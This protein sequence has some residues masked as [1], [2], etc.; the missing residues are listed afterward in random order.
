MKEIA[1]REEQPLTVTEIRK[2]VNLIQEV[3][4]DI[5]KKDEHYGIIPGCKKPSLL[6]PGAE[7]IASTF[8]IHIESGE[9]LVEDLST[10]DKAHFRVTCKAYQNGVCLG[11]SVGVCSS[12]EEKYKW[13]KPTCD[14]EWEEADP[15]QR[16]EKWVKYGNEKA[17]KWKQIRTQ[18]ADLENTILQMADKR[19]YVAL[20]R[21]VTAASDVFAMNIEDL[22]PD[23]LDNDDK[24]KPI[25]QPEARKPDTDETKPDKP[26]GSV[27]SEPQ[28]KRLYAICKSADVSDETMKAFLLKYGFESSKDIT[29]D[30]YTEICKAVEKGELAVD[31]NEIDGCSLDPNSCDHSV[32]QDSYA[33]CQVQDSKICKFDKGNP[34]NG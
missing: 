9:G 34:L 17:K 14:E 27:I 24:R 32:W 25:K 15:S 28:R 2:Q 6:K 22:P 18:P 13:K 3:M 4:R 16:R 33:Y 26:S 19:G 8:H 30:K 5:M 11:S 29:K 20:V 12:D 1:L 21:K 7:K 23:M 31:A 10:P